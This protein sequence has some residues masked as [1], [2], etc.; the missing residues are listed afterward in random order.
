MAWKPSGYQSLSPYLLVE[1]VEATLAFCEAVFA[2]ER[3]RLEPGGAGGM[4]AEMR[5][6]DTI[7]MIGGPVAPG[8][9]MLHLYCAD[10]DAVMARALAQEARQLEAV[11]DRKDGS[12][13]GGFLAPDGTQWFVA[14]LR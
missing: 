12:R 7:V 13:R 6:D 1:D 4:H 10:P 14:C 9:A 8:N 3:L 5:I 11:G 2:A